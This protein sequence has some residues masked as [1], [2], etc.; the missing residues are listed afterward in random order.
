MSSIASGYVIAGRMI[1]SATGPACPTVTCRNRLF[2]LPSAAVHRSPAYV[3]APCSAHAPS[4]QQSLLALLISDGNLTRLAFRTTRCPWPRFYPRPSG[5]IGVADAVYGI[6]FAHN[7]WP[8]RWLHHGRQT[9]NY[10]FIP[11]YANYRSI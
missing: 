10:A 11:L 7:P 9:Y 8:T 5:H 2:I 4:R 6:Y 3:F 1:S